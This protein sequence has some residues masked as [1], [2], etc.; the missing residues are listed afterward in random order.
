MTP[1][2]RC[3]QVHLQGATSVLFN[4]LIMQ[5]HLSFS[6]S[7]WA[8]NL[9]KHQR[10]VAAGTEDEPGAADKQKQVLRKSLVGV[11]APA[12]I[13]PPSPR[14]Q[15]ALCARQVSRHTHSRAPDARTFFLLLHLGECR[16]SFD[17][18][19]P[20]PLRPFYPVSWELIYVSLMSQHVRLD[21]SLPSSPHS[22]FI[23][24][25]EGES[26]F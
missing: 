2:R 11:C 10:P 6:D 5:S 19:P 7:L 14:V 26:T 3:T 4:S 25:E 18:P 20:P 1:R 8:Q 23:I 12:I 24:G 15:T 21:L 16:A 9:F 22:S 17:A 13:L